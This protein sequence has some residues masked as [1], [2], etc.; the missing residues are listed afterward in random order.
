MKKYVAV[1]TKFWIGHAVA[2]LWTTFSIIVSLPWV[3][4][5]SKIVSLPV[6]VLIIAGISYLPGYINAFMVVSLLLDRQPSFR[7][8]NR[9]FQ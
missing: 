5:L 2:A 1:K 7:Y 6:S 3:F 4:E 9:K 8:L